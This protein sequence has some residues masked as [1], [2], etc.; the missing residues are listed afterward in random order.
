MGAGEACRGVKYH[1][2]AEEPTREAPTQASKSGFFSCCSSEADKQQHETDIFSNA[3]LKPLKRPRANGDYEKLK[4]GYEE[5]GRNQ[6]KWTSP[7]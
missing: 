7:D 5:I 6:L 4:S 2:Y 3:N 1:S